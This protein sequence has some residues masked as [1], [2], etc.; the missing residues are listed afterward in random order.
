MPLL[1]AAWA[2]AGHGC[3]EFNARWSVGAP[4]CFEGA[5]GFNQFIDVGF[6]DLPKPAQAILEQVGNRLRN[7][8]LLLAKAG[9]QEKDIDPLEAVF[10][11]LDE[12]KIGRY[13]AV[14]AELLREIVQS[15]GVDVGS[16]VRSVKANRSLLPAKPTEVRRS[17]SSIRC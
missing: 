9:M 15:G 6:E 5:T 1:P 10:E 11:V 14:D 4:T 2:Q 3:V 16:M 7:R 13:T 17:A 8:D 12:E